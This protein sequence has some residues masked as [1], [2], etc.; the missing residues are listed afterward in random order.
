[1]KDKLKKKIIINEVR[2]EEES[3]GKG[4]KDSCPPPPYEEGRLKGLKNYKLEDLEAKELKVKGPKVKI[5]P[6]ISKFPREIENAK[7]A[8]NEGKV[9]L[10]V[11]HIKIE[12]VIQTFKESLEPTSILMQLINTRL[13]MGWLIVTVTMLII[14][15]YFFITLIK[16]LL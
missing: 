15:P 2:H 7:I 9:P 10:S 13:L 1:M 8:F 12:E 5:G 4:A 6:K 3:P 14:L 11:D 16:H